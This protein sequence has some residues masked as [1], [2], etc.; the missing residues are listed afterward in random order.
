MKDPYE[1]VWEEIEKGFELNTK[2]I[3]WIAERT[4]SVKD[5]KEFIDEFTQKHDNHDNHDE[6]LDF[7][8]KERQ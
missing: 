7:L 1:K 5:Y 3:S 8:R 6:L 2:M 4:L